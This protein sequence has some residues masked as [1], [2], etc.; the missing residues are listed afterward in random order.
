MLGAAYLT[1]LVAGFPDEGL[2]S[3]IAVGLV[4]FG[5]VPVVIGV[6][7]LLYSLRMGACILRFPWQTLQVRQELLSWGGS[8]AVALGPDG[9]HVLFLVAIR[10]RW[11][12]FEGFETLLF[13]GDPDR[14]GV[15][16][17]PR[18]DLVWVRRPRGA[19]YRRHLQR[20]VAK[21][22]RS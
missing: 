20:R 9:E 19:W 13:A 6:G 15:V 21:S 2:A 5:I 17:T 12:T 11:E 7:S 16:S 4:G 10:P 18:G 3:N 1:L 22:N 14:R 8:P